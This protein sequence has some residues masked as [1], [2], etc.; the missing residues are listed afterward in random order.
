MQ[1]EFA[2]TD[3]PQ[4]HPQRA[5]DILARH[6]EV[7][8]LFGRNAFSAL[9]VFGL[10]AIQLAAAFLLLVLAWAV[11]FTAARSVKVEPVPLT[12]KGGRP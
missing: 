8:E 7:R 6:P 1:L 5:R 12:T 11:L 2:H 4:D 10:V 3:A 9:F